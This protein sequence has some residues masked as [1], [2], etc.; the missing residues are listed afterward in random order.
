MDLSGFKLNINIGIIMLTG[1][2][3]Q[4]QKKAA[5]LYLQFSGIQFLYANF[6]MLS[7]V[8][9]MVHLKD[10]KEIQNID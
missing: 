2:M 10:G 5:D 8:A 3:R 4:L 9:L 6:L 7:R 1:L